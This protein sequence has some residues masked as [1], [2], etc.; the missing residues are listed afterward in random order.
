MSCSSNSSDEFV[1]PKVIG[2]LEILRCELLDELPRAISLMEGMKK[3]H[4]VYLKIYREANEVLF[5]E[6][7]ISELK[8][9]VKNHFAMILFVLDELQ[10]LLDGKIVRS[11][12]YKLL[13]AREFVHP[14]RTGD[15]IGGAS[16]NSSSSPIHL[17]TKSIEGYFF[18][19]KCALVGKVSLLSTFVLTVLTVN[20]SILTRLYKEE[21]LR[22]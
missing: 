6:I 16:H 10:F 9:H 8:Y 21:I 19:E 22:F 4:K 18:E 2:Y 20:F 14:T 12:K 11:N 15:F 7:L 5:P 17:C 1:S 3:I 13:I